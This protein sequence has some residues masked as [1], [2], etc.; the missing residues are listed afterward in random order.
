[1]TTSRSKILFNTEATFLGTGYGVYGHQVLTRLHNTGKYEIA[2]LGSF[3]QSDDARISQIPWKFFPVERGDNPLDAFGQSCFNT[4]VAKYKPAV[5]CSFRDPWMCAFESSSPLRAY[6]KHVIMPTI[7]AIPQKDNWLALYASA[8]KVLTYTDW[9]LEVLKEDLQKENVFKSAS[10]AADYNLF[11]PIQNRNEF[12]KRIN[13]APESLV[14]GT[15]M[16]NQKRKL[17]PSLIKMFEQLYT[18]SPKHIKDNL[19]LYLHTSWPDIGWDIPSLIKESFLSHRILMTYFCSSCG[20]VFPSVFHYAVTTCRGCGENSARTPSTQQPITRELLATIMQT[21][22]VYVQYASAGGFEMPQVEAAACGVPVFSI[23][24]A[25]MS[26]VVRKIEGYPVK[27]S[28]FEKEL[29]THRYMA[30]PDNDDCAQQILSL[31]KLPE[32]MRRVKGLKCA[33]AARKQYTWDN[34]AKVWEEAIDSVL[35]SYNEKL[36]LSS[37]DIHTPSAQIPKADYTT[38]VKHA[39]VHIANRPDLLN[40]FVEATLIRD[41]LWGVKISNV[42][43][44]SYNELSFLSS[45]PN[46]TKFTVEDLVNECIMMCEEK[47][48]CEYDRV[49]YI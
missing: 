19:Y 32:P 15:V 9:A 39:L 25:A 43:G 38:I 27:V 28:H 7:D 41:L 20:A 36:W 46:L 8:D 37:P 33:D 14:I 5:V 22:D 13:L 21:F 3:S 23:D 10:P 49:N 16:R 4:V 44:Y 12:R 11:K 18:N 17:Y 48:K 31:L 45:M 42:S 40:T 30:F 1:M 6:Y 26:D 29:E 24:Y 2:E 35:E 34:A 47:N